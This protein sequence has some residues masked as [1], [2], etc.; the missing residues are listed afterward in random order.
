MSQVIS[1]PLTRVH[2]RI[3]DE[4]SRL[5]FPITLALEYNLIGGKRII[6]GIGRTI[7]I[8]STGLLFEAADD[9]D[10]TQVLYGSRIELVL[11]WPFQRSRSHPLKLRLRGSIVRGD[12]RLIAMSINQHAFD[13][14]PVESN[15]TRAARRVSASIDALQRS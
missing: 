2:V 10:R 4:R 13:A 5:R 11:N 15:W 1:L 14:G 3:V 12:G 7:N 9:I 8:S 6:R